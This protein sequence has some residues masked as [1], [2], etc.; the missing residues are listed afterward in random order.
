LLNAVGKSSHRPS[1][2]DLVKKKI[3]V[4]VSDVAETP[5]QPMAAK[6]VQREISE[7]QKFDWLH[8]QKIRQSQSRGIGI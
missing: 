7:T 8:K 6:N 5:S 3:S 1:A 2:T 4:S